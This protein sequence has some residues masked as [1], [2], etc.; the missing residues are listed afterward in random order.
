M[1]SNLIYP[2]GEKE[3]P[4]LVTLEHKLGKCVHVE[5]STVFNITKI[6]L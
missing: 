1:A 4:M 5:N 3:M 6:I 2:D